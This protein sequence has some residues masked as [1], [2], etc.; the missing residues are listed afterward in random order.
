MEQAQAEPKVS[1]PTRGHRW[2]RL[3]VVVVVVVDASSSVVLA[4]H[5]LRLKLA[6]QHHHHLIALTWPLDELA[7]YVVDAASESCYQCQ[8]LLLL[9]VASSTVVDAPS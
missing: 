3:V 6:Q 5:A 9:R 8:L 4:D 2:C 7:L 1:Q